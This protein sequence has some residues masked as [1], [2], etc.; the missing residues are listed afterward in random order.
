LPLTTEPELIWL[1]DQL[2]NDFCLCRLQSLDAEAAVSN[3]CFGALAIYKLL[4]VSL[5]LL[6]FYAIAAQAE[7]TPKDLQVATRSLAFL[8]G[9]DVS[10]LRIAILYAPDVPASKAEADGLSA[11]VGGSLS[12][13]RVTLVPVSPLL[14]SVGNLPGLEGRDVAFVTSGLEPYQSAIAQAAAARKIVTITADFACVTSGNCVLGV[15]SE[16]RV[17]LL[18]SRSAAQ[19]TATEFAPG[20]RL[21]VN[22]L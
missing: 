5:V 7:M 22:E 2:S 6:A 3:R 1:G 15:H 21:L 17:Q 13:S 10:H 14:L 12:A 4:P 19:A 18:I 9:R 11:A 8:T 20:F 16:P